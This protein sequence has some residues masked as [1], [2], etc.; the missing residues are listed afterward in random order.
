MAKQLIGSKIGGVFNNL[1]FDDETNGLKFKKADGVEVDIVGDNNGGGS[2]IKMI[3]MVRPI[4]DEAILPKVEI[5]AD[6][7]FATIAKTIDASIASDRSK[8]MVYAEDYG[9]MALNTDGVGGSGNGADGIH[10]FAYGLGTP[11]DNAVVLCDLSGVDLEEPYF[12]RWCWQTI[13]GDG[14]VV[15]TTVDGVSSN[16]A[17]GW[18]STQFPSAP[19]FTPN[20]PNQGTLRTVSMTQ[21]QYDAMEIH[22]DN[23]L[24]VIIG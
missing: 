20:V 9:W 22:D 19:A 3:Q 8:F 14:N 16:V 15:T 21:E 5:S 1:S 6:E 24:Y 2:S 7:S 13:D 4:S 11:F 17:T 12:I 23:T 18:Q 10:D